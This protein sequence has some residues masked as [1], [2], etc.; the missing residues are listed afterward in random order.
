[1]SKTPT[2]TIAAAALMGM[3]LQLMQPAPAWGM[4]RVP[5]TVPA[6]ASAPDRDDLDALPFGVGYEARQGGRQ[7][8][9]T[10]SPSVGRRGIPEGRGSG[11]GTGSG[12]SAR[13]GGASRGSPSG[14]R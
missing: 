4:A 9:A 6:E 5:R 14:H 3:A 11:Q 7:A 12:A 2:S 13:S 1:M 8:A 10:D